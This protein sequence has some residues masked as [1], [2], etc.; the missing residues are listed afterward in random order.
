MSTHRIDAAKLIKGIGLV[1][2]Y[3]MN[4]MV[5]VLIHLGDRLNLFKTMAGRDRF[6]S[7]EELATHTGYEARWLKEWLRGMVAAKILEYQEGTDQTERFKLTPEMGEVLAN[8]DTSLN[9][10]AGAFVGMMPA[11]LSDGLVDTFKT[12]AGMSYR[13]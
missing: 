4:Q 3:K 12:G 7:T 11:A 6:V 2:N 1:Y 5:S 9:F 10:A 8:E 13:A